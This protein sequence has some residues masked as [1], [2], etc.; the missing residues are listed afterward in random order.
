MFIFFIIFPFLC[1]LPIAL[2]G[3]CACCGKNENK[4][5]EIGDCY[6]EMSEIRAESKTNIEYLCHDNDAV[7][8]KNEVISSMVVMRVWTYTNERTMSM[9]RKS[10][11][12]HRRVIASLMTGVFMLQQTDLNILNF[13]V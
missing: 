4:P 12:T 11:K 6:R 2:V 9:T 13:L 7:C 1:V 8:A 3:F 5:L 10:R